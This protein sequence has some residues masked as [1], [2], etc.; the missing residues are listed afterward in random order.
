[1]IQTR[2]VWSSFVAILLFFVTACSAPPPTQDWVKGETGTVSRIV[3]GDTLVLTGGQV[4]RLVSIEAPSPAYRDRAEAPHA[5]KSKRMLERLVLGRDVQLYYPGITRDRYDR[6]LAQVY[7]QTE[8]GKDIWVNASMV[9]QGGAYVR[10]YPDTARGSE[11]LWPLERTARDDEAG[12][13]G[14]RDYAP[15]QRRVEREETGF[16]LLWDRPVRQSFEDGRCKWPLVSSGLEAVLNATNSGACQA[17]ED[18]AEWRGFVRDGRL[19]ISSVQNI[20]P[21]APDRPPSG[22][23]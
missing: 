4:V 10:I 9:A 17:P 11:R 14:L 5:E 19:Y 20:R 8:T 18:L 2:S 1:M 16:M 7:A 6:A 12:L 21:I 23:D 3:D 22:S 13:W 15:I